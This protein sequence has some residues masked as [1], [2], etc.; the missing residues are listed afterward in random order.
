MRLLAIDYGDKKLG[1]ALSDG[2]GL[3]VRPLVT[4]ERVPKERSFQRIIAIVEEHSVEA[5]VVG[6]PLRLDGSAGDAALRVGRFMDELRSR[7][8]CPIVGWDEKLTSVEAEE[9]MRLSG[10]RPAERK[11][12]IDQYAA[13]VLLEDYINSR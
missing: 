7:L 2:L 9:R 5:V 13:M 3:T 6:V 8:A 4:L 10:L 11:E 12:K 1:L